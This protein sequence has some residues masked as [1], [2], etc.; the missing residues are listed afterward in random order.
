MQTTEKR[1]YYNVFCK[2]NG[3]KIKIDI[4][5][6]FRNTSEISYC[7]EFLDDAGKSKRYYDYSLKY[8]E[9]NGEFLV[10]LVFDFDFYADLH[11]ARLIQYVKDRSGEIKQIL[12]SFELN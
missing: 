1:I 6:V 3:V 8:Y 11:N 2:N 12:Y 9:K 10:F 5:D 4:T 7:V